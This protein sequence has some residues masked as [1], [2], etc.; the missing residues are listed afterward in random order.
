MD[1]DE[2]MRAAARRLS[3]DEG[4]RAGAKCLRDLRPM[5]VVSEENRALNAPDKL[6]EEAESRARKQAR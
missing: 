1:R 6:I 3:P 4:L 2:F 5:V